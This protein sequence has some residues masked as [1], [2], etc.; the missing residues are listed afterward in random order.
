MQ[1]TLNVG[2]VGYKFMG[3]AHSNAYRQVAAF[4]PDVAFHPVM[5]AICGRDEEAVRAAAAQ[6]GWEGYETDWRKL[7][8]RDD[9]DLIDISTPGDTHNPI[10]VAAAEHGK[11]IFCEKPLARDMSEARR[12]LAAVR[13]A[14]VIA[15]VNF[16]YRRVPAVQLAK[17]LIDE[18]RIGRIYHWRCAYLQ[19]GGADPRRPMT[20]RQQKV[21]AGSGAIGDL[22]VHV[23]D[24]AR[25]LIGDI[26]NVTGLTTTFI[27]QR[28]I[29][30]AEDQTGTVDVD[31]AALWLA[32][33]ANGAIGSFEVTKLATGRRNYNSFEINGSKGS[34]VFNL[35]RLNELNVVFT[36][37]PPE[38][39]GFRNILV[40]DRSHKYVSAWWPAGHIIGWEHTFTHG[41]YDLL[42]GI[43]SGTPP[44]ATFVDGLRA[45]AV[46]EAVERSSGRGSWVEPDYSE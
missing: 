16:N 34:I 26:T 32:R 45:Q 3:K 25:F 17:Q 46:V 1:K 6:F 11:H 40:T 13:Q 28:P 15:M 22:G 5:K 23:I 35:E 41:I 2:I 44:A 20:W 10:A 43:G 12:M 42:N 24:L 30:G 8:A 14:G 21:H 29:A 18:G 39:R 27:K 37:D 33:F 4:F 38:I 31:D 19:E 9:I 7:V 36:D